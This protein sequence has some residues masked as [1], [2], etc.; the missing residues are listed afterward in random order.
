MSYS[1]LSCDGEKK[2][3]VRAVIKI[4]CVLLRRQKRKLNNN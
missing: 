3:V 2:C 4:I 1:D